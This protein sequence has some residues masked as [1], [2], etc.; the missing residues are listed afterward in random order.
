M[1]YAFDQKGLQ[2]N[3]LLRKTSELKRKL[4]FITLLLFS[5][6]DSFP[7]KAKVPLEDLELEKVADKFS[8]SSKDGK[9]SYQ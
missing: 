6:C 1:D 7:Q 2:Y 9:L 4:S 5:C 8:R 3:I